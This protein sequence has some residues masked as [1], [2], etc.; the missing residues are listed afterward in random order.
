VVPGKN[1]VWGLHGV[2]GRIIWGHL[3]DGIDKQYGDPDGIL[4]L[5]RNRVHGDVMVG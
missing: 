5:T 4:L 1:W 2:P 3:V